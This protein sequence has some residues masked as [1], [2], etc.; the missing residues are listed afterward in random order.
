MGILK[1]NWMINQIYGLR[2]MGHGRAH[3]ILISMRSSKNYIL[4]LPNIFKTAN[5]ISSF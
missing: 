5:E 1:K 4:D 3:Q 2:L